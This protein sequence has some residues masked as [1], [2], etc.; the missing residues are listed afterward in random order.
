MTLEKFNDLNRAE[1]ASY[2]TA[3]CGSERWVNA[4]LDS[5]PFADREAVQSR[6][7][8]IWRSLSPSDWLEAFGKHPRIGETRDLSAWSSEEQSGMESAGSTLVVELAQLNIDYYDRFG[9]IFILCA[10]GKT[11]AEML[12]AL[13]ARV[14]NA[15]EREIVIAAAEQ[16]KI[17][18]L[19]LEKL[20]A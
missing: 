20:L 4:M 16:A 3:C 18:A 14:V 15:P 9:Y 7:L 1:A 6:A 19:R 8:Q 2:L 11:A 12:T 17:T 13:R 5:R 10:T